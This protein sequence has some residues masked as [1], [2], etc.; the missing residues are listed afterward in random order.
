MRT[1]HAARD[2]SLG[3]DGAFRQIPTNINR[4]VRACNTTFWTRQ[5][6]DITRYGVWRTIYD[7]IAKT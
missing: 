6:C 2:Y 4:D 1:T 3:C 5:F 7:I